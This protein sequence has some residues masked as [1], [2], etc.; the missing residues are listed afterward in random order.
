MVFLL[1]QRRRQ[2]SFVVVFRELMH[3]ARDQIEI[4]RAGRFI[5]QNHIWR[6]EP[7]RDQ[8]IEH[9]ARILVRRSAGNKTHSEGRLRRERGRERDSRGAGDESS[10]GWFH[11]A[12]AQ[13]QCL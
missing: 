7:R 12:F 5:G 13:T 9:D 10:I 4:R 6:V 2:R 8:I 11:C 1:F 3:L